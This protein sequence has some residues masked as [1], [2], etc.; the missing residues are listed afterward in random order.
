MSKNFELMQQAG[1]DQEFL[2]GR[3]IRAAAPAPGVGNGGNGRNASPRNGSGLDVTQLAA[4]EA[5]RLVHRVF[6]NHV[7]DPAR[8]VVFAGVDGGNGCS[9]ICV[10]VAIALAKNMQGSVCLVEANLHSPSLPGMF[11]TTNHHGLTDALS[12]EGPIRTFAKLVHGQNLWLLSTGSMDGST[13]SV[14]HLEKMKTRVAELRKEFDYV[15]I[16]APPLNEY[17]EAMALGQLADG[18]ILVLEANST[19]REAAVRIVENLRATQIRLL[20]AVLN[21]RT[22][23]IPQSL[24]KLL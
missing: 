15:L 23:P 19:R 11:G 16:D 13:G 6:L 4:E 3:P 1:R 14:L 20:G 17:S 9:L 21:K 7:Q 10:D 2:A 18:L 22:F 5:L 8:A 24:Y 12:T